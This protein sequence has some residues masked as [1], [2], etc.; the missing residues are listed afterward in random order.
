MIGKEPALDSENGFFEKW[1]HNEVNVLT[2]DDQSSS[3]A[4]EPSSEIEGLLS[5]RPDLR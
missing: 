4:Q 3:E 1:E 2:R 5:T